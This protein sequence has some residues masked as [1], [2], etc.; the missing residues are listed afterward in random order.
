MKRNQPSGSSQHEAGQI[1]PFDANALYETP[2]PRSVEEPPRKKQKR[3]EQA[4]LSVVVFWERRDHDMLMS[5][6]EL[7]LD[8]RN[9]AV[10]AKIVK[11]MTRNPTSRRRV[12]YTPSDFEDGRVYGSG[13][14]GVCGWIRRLCSFKYYHDLDIENCAPTLLR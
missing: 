7:V 10:V 6:I 13:L 9:E 3:G 4:G 5:I 14:Q 11:E 12:H 2:A 8:P 1:V